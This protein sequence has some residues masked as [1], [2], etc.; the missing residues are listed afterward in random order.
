MG[1]RSRSFCVPEPLKL[2]ATIPP[3]TAIRLS[4][5]SRRALISLT[6]VLVLVVAACQP[7]ALSV[8]PSPSASQTPAPTASPSAGGSVTPSA[9]GSPADLSATYASIEDQVRAIRGLAAK[10]AVDP[11]VLDDA[12]I[13][14]I[15]AD[16]FRK[17]NPQ[18]LVDAN[19]RLLKGLG[20]LPQD[21]NLGD[22][23]VKLL[24]EQVAGL[25][26]PDDKQLY[27]VS[28]SGKLGPTE[29]TTFAHEYTHALQD[30]NFDLGSLKLDEVGEGDKGIAGLS[31]VEGDATLV[32]SLW[33]IQHLS[34]VELLQLLSESLSPE[35][36]GSLDERIRQVIRAMQP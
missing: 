3:M 28:R 29:K 22:L 11:V 25:Y 6:A 27:V 10:K 34:Q 5:G 32:M 1:R 36:S 4:R 12:G 9:P 30:Q 16:G 33:Q 2:S 26:S 14:K 18:A 8:S 17:D 24:G 7:A 35:V 31:L 20:L 13:K 15:T 19:E 23:Y 21:A